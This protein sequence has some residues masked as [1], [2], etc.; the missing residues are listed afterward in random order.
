[1]PR[2]G[3]RLPAACT[4][5]LLHADLILHAG[6][7]VALPVLRELQEFGEVIAVH[8]N[9]DDDEVRAA[10]P[11]ETLVDAAGA[12]IGLIHDAGPARCRHRRLRSL[13]PDAAGV[14]FGHSHLPLHERV[15]DGLQ[16]FNPGSPTDKRRAPSHTM[17]LARTSPGGL[18]FELLELE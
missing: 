15:T 2:G 9:V 5:R 6:D 12:K 13:F 18:R 1:M 11:A 7:L 4:S 14:V 10:L 16:I 8:G 3:R 17:G